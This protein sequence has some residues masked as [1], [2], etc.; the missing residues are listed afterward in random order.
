MPG[1]NKK[2][3][4]KIETVCEKEKDNGVKKKYL[5]ALKKLKNKWLKKQDGFASVLQQHLC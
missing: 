5:D 1:N 3:Q 4:P 2:L